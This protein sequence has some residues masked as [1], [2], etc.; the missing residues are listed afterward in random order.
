MATNMTPEFFIGR[1]QEFTLVGQLLSQAQGARR[2]LL[3]NGPGGFGKTRL[4]FELHKQRDRIAELLELPLLCFAPVDFDDVAMRLPTSLLGHLA[5]QLDP[6]ACADYY[7]EQDKYTR[8][9]QQGAD[10]DVIQ[11]HLHRSLEAFVQGY[12]QTVENKL[13]L[14]LLDTFETV[15]NSELPPTLWN[16]LEQLKNTVV[17]IAGRHMDE[18]AS[19]LLPR[20]GTEI[21]HQHELQS[22]SA[23]EASNYLEHTEAS[24]GL[25]PEIKEKI[26]ILTEGHPIL[27]ALAEYWLRRDVPLNHI[28]SRPLEELHSLPEEKLKRRRQDFEAVLVNK[29]LDLTTIDQALLRMA[30]LHREFNDDILQA[31]LNLTPG[32]VEEISAELRQFPFVKP[33]PG[34][35]YALHDEMRRLVV[36][37]SWPVVDP[38]GLQRRALAQR[39]TKQY[40][41]P[42]INDLDQQIQ[43]MRLVDE[44]RK[45][46]ATTLIRGG[47]LGLRKWRLEAD[48]LYYTLELNAKTGYEYFDQLFEIA[49]GSNNL[50]RCELLLNTVDEQKEKLAPYPHFLTNLQIKRARWQWLSDQPEIKEQAGRN[51]RELMQLPRL[52]KRNRIEAIS[53]VAGRTGDVQEAIRLRR[54]CVQ[55]A[56]QIGD[57]TNLARMYN[58]LGLAYRRAGQWKQAMEWYQKAREQAEDIRDKSITA[59]AISHMAYIARLQ[60]HTDQ[61][62]HLCGLALSL[63]RAAGGR[64]RDLA[65]SYQ[66][67]GEVYS[68]MRLTQRALGYFE[69]AAEICRRF[70]AQQELAQALGHI[71]NIHRQQHAPREVEKYLNEAITF[72]EQAQNLAGLAASYGEYGCEYRKRA[73]ERYRKG[74]PGE[75]PQEAMADFAKAE[76]YFLKGLDYARRCGEKYRETDILIDMALLEFYCYRINQGKT[77][78]KKGK[79]YLA[80]AERIAKKYDY[81]LFQGRAEELR[82]N[83]D[84]TDGKLESAFLQHFV[85][86]S[87]LLVG[88]PSER[89]REAIERVQYR[90]RELAEET[91]RSPKEIQRLLKELVKVFKANGAKRFADLIKEC[92]AVQKYVSWRGGPNARA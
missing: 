53:T 63:R 65:R 1:D 60:G 90:I 26:F 74:E 83:F 16:I 71:A 67:Y 33:R 56:Q 84:L 69:Q 68:D 73:W 44:D 46:L 40:Y 22:F 50:R 72:H 4:L 48:R 91:R 92:R 82:G 10:Y 62:E 75:Y 23:L 47:D 18:A 85:Q 87:L 80:Q 34:N 81:V 54:R 30:Y 88:Y 5:N 32:Q 27:V 37:H 89:Y 2:V 24:A 20:W 28:V 52:D 11:D 70:G 51:L 43:A 79:Q 21:V 19:M 61:A 14:I 41:A 35:D 6:S 9:E 31:S 49:L 7:S 45:S 13:A 8:L 57:K 59:D 29:I 58:Y 64:E 76:E 12:T 42:R 17:V 66:T 25:D 36:R 86:A 78:S 77:H 15:A 39:I 55:L 38:H 3:I